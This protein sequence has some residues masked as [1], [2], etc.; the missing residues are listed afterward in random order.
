MV[1]YSHIIFDLDGTL[2]NS[3]VG[4]ENSLNYMF[5]RMDHD[6]IGSV[7]VDRLIGPPI[8]D[9]LKNVLGF[10][11]RQVE[12]GVRLFREYYST[13]GLYEGELYA[14]IAEL[15]AELAD[16]GTK[17][18]VATSK[19]D[20]F[21]EIVLREFGLDRYLTD[22]QGSGDGGLHTKAGIIT[23][24]LDRNQLIPSP[25]MVMIGDT[26]FDIVGG[27]ANEISTIGVGYGY[28]DADEIRSLQPDYFAD[29]VDDLT[30][31]LVY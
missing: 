11:E 8:Q 2:L 16:R 13:K 26:K 14:G 31:H 29:D 21:T 19:K 30:E 27:K 7:V 17:L 12:L 18:Y 3:K 9:G 10:D 25:N 20:R 4:I 22:F 24:L 5:S 23:Q 28:G 1:N 6:R 15:L